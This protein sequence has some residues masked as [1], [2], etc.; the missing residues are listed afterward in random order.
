MTDSLDQMR[1]LFW[2]ELKKQQQQTPQEKLSAM[3]DLAAE[4][5]GQQCP[6]PDRVPLLRAR[7]ETLGLTLRDQELQRF[8]WDARRAAAGAIEPLR[9]GDRI[10]L[11]PE[12]W[13]WQGVLMAECLNLVVALPKAGKTSLLLALIGAWHRGQPDFLGLPL[14][15]PCPS[16]LI[17]G[18]DQPQ[19]DW[20]RML[21]QVEL[22]GDQNEIVYPVVG[23]FH[24]GRPLHLD[25]EGIERISSIA[26]QH[27]G[28]WVLLDSISACTS[29]L[30]L[31]ENSAEIVEPINDLMEA[32]G[33][34]RATVA[35]VHH[36][37]KSRQGESATLASRGSTALP[38]AASQVISLERRASAP[39]GS[40]DRR[41]VL[42]TEGR[43]GLP[44]Q[45]LIER[46][47]D[48]WISHG[49]AETVAMAQHMQEVEEKLS[50][51]QADALEVVRERWANG[52][53]P[54]DAKGLADAL[55]LRG[56][57]E[58]KARATLDQL[59]R[60]RLLLS[61]VESGSQSRRKLFRPVTA[62]ASRGVFSDASE[63]S[64]P[65]AALAYVDPQPISNSFPSKGSE[66]KEGKEGPENTPRETLPTPPDQSDP[67]QSRP[68]AIRTT[69]PAH[70]PIGS[71][72]DAFD[73]E[74]DDPA[75][76]PRPEPPNASPPA[77]A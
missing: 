2:E 26:A 54:T 23:L 41:L 42:K 10:D 24:K 59:A 37:G 32:V 66:G 61:S 62:E 27:P 19:S 48:G 3:R 49:S 44:Q 9:P 58:R 64:E 57:A 73:D 65:S 43:G 69:P 76:P 67:T 53:L 7:A 55:G 74:G 77:A 72:S 20:G 40:Q 39:T 11:A 38:A 63:P 13:H 75:W 68:E 34:Y 25:F 70:N 60:R 45:L 50:D 31:D 35:A 1:R 17:V 33:P 36:S 4:L 47:E 16:V 52:Q 15:G 18:T 30:G 22:L 51:R 8:L 12:P 71:G 56:E 21:R 29:P 5:L 46:T 14:I 6:F 28:L